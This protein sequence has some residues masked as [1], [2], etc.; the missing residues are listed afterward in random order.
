[1]QLVFT[2]MADFLNIMMKATNVDHSEFYGWTVT[3]QERNNNIRGSKE[4]C[5]EQDE[6]SSSACLQADELET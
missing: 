6:L 4:A 1:M 3:V 5:Y 2:C